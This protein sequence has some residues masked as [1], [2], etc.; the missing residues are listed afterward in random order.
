[1]ASVFQTTNVCFS[2]VQTDLI[3]TENVGGG[4]GWE[5]MGS[6]VEEEGVGVGG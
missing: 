5:E 1:M 3:N 2:V 6:G 4:T